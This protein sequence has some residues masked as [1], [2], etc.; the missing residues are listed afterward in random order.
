MH[1]ARSG[2]ETFLQEKCMT[3]SKDWIVPPWLL[4]LLALLLSVLLGLL[5]I[6]ALRPHWL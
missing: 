3:A 2:R 5:A 4:A 1:A 6:A